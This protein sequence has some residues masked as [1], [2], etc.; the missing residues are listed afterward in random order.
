LSDSNR[1]ASV[2]KNGRWIN[3]DNLDLWA[4]RFCVLK[5]H[6]NEE[7]DFCLK[8]TNFIFVG[9]HSIL[10]KYTALVNR[11]NLSPNKLDSGNTFD[12]SMLLTKDSNQEQTLNHVFVF[13]PRLKSVF[14]DSL[15]KQISSAFDSS[16]KGK[17]LNNFKTTIVVV[18]TGHYYLREQNIQQGVKAWKET[19]DTTSSL[20][21]NIT[22]SS[23]LT[24]YFSPVPPVVEDKLSSFNYGALHM[25]AID[26]MNFYL[27]QLNSNFFFPE[28]WSQ[29]IKSRPEMTSDG[30]RYS[31]ELESHL[32]N[33]IFN[34]VCNPIKN[35]QSYP[36]E[37][38]CCSKYPTPYPNE[39]FN[40]LFGFGLVLL[41]VIL[42]DR[43]PLFEKH[44]KI[45]TPFYFLMF[46]AIFCFS[47]FSSFKTDQKSPA[48]F[49]QEL[50][51]EIKG[52]SSILL[53]LCS[54]TRVDESNT[55]FKL[56]AF[57][58]SLTLFSSGVLYHEMF[59]S[60]NNN[61]QKKV[62][63]FAK[64]LFSINIIAF[65]L[66]YLTNTPYYKYSYIVLDSMVLIL[67]FVLSVMEQDNSKKPKAILTRILGFALA[68]LAI[69]NFKILEFI[70][71]VVNSIMGTGFDPL[72]FI[73]LVSCYLYSGLAGIA[74]GV[75]RDHYEEREFQRIAS[76]YRTRVVLGSAFCLSLYILLCTYCF[77][78]QTSFLAFHK[79]ISILGIVPVCVLYQLVKSKSIYS[80][81][82]TGINEHYH[83]L[84]SLQQHILLGNSGK[85]IILYI[86]INSKYDFLM[87]TNI[88]WLINFCI[89]LFIF[90]CTASILTVVRDFILE[91]IV[92]C[93]Y[94]DQIATVLP[95]MRQ[96][97]GEIIYSE[98]PRPSSSKDQHSSSALGKEI[99][100]G[101]ENEGV[102]GYYN[103]SS[104]INM[105]TFVVSSSHSSSETS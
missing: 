95:V 23:K 11:L 99:D 97:T 81:M 50:F 35:M 17:S 78:S 52:F 98:Q 77:E 54:Y 103:N 93:L 21:Q 70:L 43:S 55:F 105:A 9:D 31:I 3:F 47:V 73:K 59:S 18:G 51:S 104:Q 25:S 42:C 53:I 75:L 6:S 22:P 29:I 65:S 79:V 26:W 32:L 7:L 34:H 96:D 91:K 61:F 80:P 69:T 71:L 85:A 102:S 16:K 82:L 58:F 86:G 19:V 15:L 89:G 49:D 14:F 5:T 94:K 12:S 38:F 63:M 84:M 1:C 88:L 2:F 48:Y 68:L 30:Y 64:S 62:F 76:H 36:F 66:G 100:I 33:T 37:A 28:S 67:A 60:C 4:P 87:Q 13:D 40:N 8:D 101:E 44:E 24:F 20:L 74:F 83:Q 41:L 72:E 90:F 56:Y 92:A 27:S 39:T 57:L 46:T 10:D 45:Y